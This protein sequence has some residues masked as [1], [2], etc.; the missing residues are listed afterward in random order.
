MDNNDRTCSI[1]SFG[2]W[3]V[4]AL[5]MLLSAP[6]ASSN[7]VPD[8]PFHS[9]TRFRLILDSDAS[10]RLTVFDING[11]PI[12]TP[13]EESLPAGSHVVDFDGTGLSAGAYLLRLEAPGE[14]MLRIIVVGG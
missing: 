12:G 11:R 9:S 4:V 8:S 6:A 14:R 10:V 1:R 5:A 7:L 3:L 2:I 13:L